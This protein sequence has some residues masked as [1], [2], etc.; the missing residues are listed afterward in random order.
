MNT[1]RSKK[2]Y[3]RK[4]RHGPRPNPTLQAFF[5]PTPTQVQPVAPVEVNSGR[6]Y[7]EVKVLAHRKVP[8]SEDHDAVGAHQ[9]G[10]RR[11][12]DADKYPSVLET[13]QA[14]KITSALGISDEQC[15][16]LRIMDSAP[17]LVL[18][19]YLEPNDHTSEIRGTV[20]DAE[21]GVVVCRSFPFTKEYAA[22]DPILSFFDL[23]NC[24]QTIAY[25][26]TIIRVYFA[27][28]QWR[29][30]THRKIDANSSRWSASRS[31]DSSNT[32]NSFGA[33]FKELWGDV[34]FGACLNPMLWYTF[35][36][37]DPNNKIICS[38]GE[39]KLYHVGTFSATQP[40]KNLLYDAIKGEVPAE[41]SL[42][43]VT[44]P[45]CNPPDVVSWGLQELR[46]QL[47]EEQLEFVK[48][49]T[50]VLVTFSNNH[51][52]KIV[53]PCY[54]SLRNLRGNEPS[55]AKRM[56]ALWRDDIK[57][58][59][60]TGLTDGEENWGC[61]KLLGLY[62]E[63]A[64]ELEAAFHTLQTTLP[65]KLADWFIRR[66]E[67]GVYLRFEKPEHLLLEATHK[68]YRPEHTVEDNI[69]YQMSRARLSLVWELLEQQKEVV[70]CW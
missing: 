12:P 1:T 5:A 58:Y 10:A 32:P 54:L 55:A 21:E 43:R 42:I 3:V 51:V 17:P 60:D 33:V 19:H 61:M 22:D 56:L 41:P 16:N 66:Y 36:I 13:G 48:R 20:V 6:K 67:K 4:D 26:G 53:P 34:E 23:T 47:V 68:Y 39:Q 44:N 11:V 29:V 46:Q 27:A 31:S 2:I 9:R 40:G 64:E 18:V 69:R 52:I 15:A 25:E 70:M 49:A 65:V 37:S 57:R 63:K 24:T 14:D 45:R 35:L 50:G 8:K 28:G 62:P 38:I 7:G 59:I 30:S